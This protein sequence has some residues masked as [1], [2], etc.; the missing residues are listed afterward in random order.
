MNA[1]V[2][3]SWVDFLRQWEGDFNS[4][5][6]WKLNFEAECHFAQQHILKSAKTIECARNNQGSLYNAIL[7]VS[8]IGISLNPALKHAYLVP[9]E[10]GIC[11]DISYRGLVK[12]ACDSGAITA[13]KAVLIHGKRGEYQGDDY[14]WNGPFS[15]PDHSG[16]TM[17]PDR[18][19]MAD[20]LENIVGGYCA[21]ILPNGS[22]IVDEM[23]AGEIFA[24][25]NT[26]KSYSSG[27]QTPWTGPWSGQMGKK[28]LVKRGSTSWPQTEGRRRF[29]MAIDILN[30][31]EGLPDSELYPNA[32]PESS[33]NAQ[34]PLCITHQQTDAL[35]EH[36][37]AAGLDKAAFCSM[38]G[39]KSVNELEANRFDN[40]VRRL[41]QIRA[42]RVI[43]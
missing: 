20:P 1:P 30:Q 4:N 32:V 19:N 12:L 31:H 9:R 2:S 22:V 29:D 5:N 38:A 7:N 39:I 11:L 41:E 6:T 33:P 36:I 16:N 3:R 18:V 34:A 17:H 21:A 15:M 37:R 43:Q 40:A 42:K 26:S 24:T 8:A 25:R 23:T 14:K 27:K 10:G 13:A 35:I 28:T